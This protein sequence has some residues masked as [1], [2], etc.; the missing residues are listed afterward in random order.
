MVLVRLR[1]R[2]FPATRTEADQLPPPTGDVEFIIGQIADWIRNADTKTGLLLTGL[3]IL[4]GAVSAHVRDLRTLWTGDAG[5]PAAVWLLGVAVVLLAAAFGF[6]VV[7]LLP[8]T[9]S[10]GASRYAWPWIAK[11]SVEDLV[12]LTPDSMRREGWQ[13]AKQLAEIAAFKY[14]FFAAVVW[15]SAVSVAC[16]LAWSI[17]RG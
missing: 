4:L 15:M 14:R 16:F 17:V 9:K 10:V 5:R 8:R 6:L 3:T 1:S 13:Q 2:P 12:R 7:V 11:T